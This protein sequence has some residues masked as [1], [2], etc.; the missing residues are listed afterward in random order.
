M[1]ENSIS[2]DAVNKYGET[3]LHASAKGRLCNVANALLRR[4]ANP[5]IQVEQVNQNLV[6]LLFD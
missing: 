2:I 1:K 4:G 3:P 6:L 5:N